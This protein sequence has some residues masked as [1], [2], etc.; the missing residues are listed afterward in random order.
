MIKIETAMGVVEI[1]QEYFAKLVGHAASECFGVAGMAFSSASQGLRQILTGKEVMD[2]GVQV[3]TSG[4]RL[5][6]DLHI[7]VAYGVN[8]SAITQSIVHKVSYV[9]EE[10]TGFEVARVN[11]FVDG[12]QKQ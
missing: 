6:I 12:I 3:R 11:V 8:I 2:K 5:I 4:R 7:I 9:V 1:T 10:A